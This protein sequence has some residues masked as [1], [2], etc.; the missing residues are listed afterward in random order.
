MSYFLSH[1]HGWR[2]LIL[3]CTCDECVGEV[4]VVA[5]EAEKDFA[6]S[7]FPA[8]HKGNF[9][10]KGLEVVGRLCRANE[11]MAPFADAASDLHIRIASNQQLSSECTSTKS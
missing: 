2:S 5:V 4:G 3:T 7:P 10:F 11:P 8:P 6:E 1:S 9:R